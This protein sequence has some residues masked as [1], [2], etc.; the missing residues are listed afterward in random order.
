[1]FFAKV[2]DALIPVIARPGRASVGRRA[3]AI[4]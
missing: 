2:E 1:M 3:E 4:F